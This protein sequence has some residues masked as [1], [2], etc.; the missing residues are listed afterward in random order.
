HGGQE[1]GFHFFHTTFF[2]AISWQFRVAAA[3]DRTLL[4]LR[5][6]CAERGQPVPLAVGTNAHYNNSQGRWPI[7]WASSSP[8]IR[9]FAV[10][11]ESRSLNPDGLR[12]SAKW[13]PGFDP[14]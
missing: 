13:C 9:T 3:Y 10:G 4:H 7:N 2:R 6:Q 14:R 11:S 12:A 1:R 8:V 5:D